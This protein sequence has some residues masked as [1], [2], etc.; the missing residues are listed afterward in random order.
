MHPGIL[1]RHAIRCAVISCAVT[2][3]H[4]PHAAAEARDT[5]LLVAISGSAATGNSP[6]YILDGRITVQNSANTDYYEFVLSGQ[7]RYGKRGDDVIA[8]SSAIR[9]S[10][11]AM[12]NAAF[13]PFAFSTVARDRVR[14]LDL[15]TTWGIGAKRTVWDHEGGNKVSVS[16]K[17]SVSVA[18]LFEFEKQESEMTSTTVPT[19]TWRW[20]LRL[21]EDLRIASLFSLATVWFWQPR[22][23][24]VRDYLLDGNLE[25]SL[26]LGGVLSTTLTYHYAFDSHPAPH[27]RN[28]DHRYL[29][30]INARF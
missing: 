4:V 11:D 2:A 8:A 5:T 29:F 1:L 22:F 28:S 19:G 9:L 27:V 25:I 16:D 13:S 17:M 23:H 21:K 15:R 26:P 30:G 14:K 24:D 6:Y 12:P 18:A 10:L 20:S 7:G 3:V